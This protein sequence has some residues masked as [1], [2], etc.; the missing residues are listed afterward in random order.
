MTEQEMVLTSVLKCRRLDLYA[1][2]RVPSDAEL[3]QILRIRS[4]RKHHEPLQ[5]ILGTCEFFGLEFSV[6]RR[7]LVPRPETELLVEASAGLLGGPSRGALNVLDIGTGSGNIIISLAQQYP[8]HHFFAIDV[9]AEALEV[10]RK[11][12]LTHDVLPRIEFAQADILSSGDQPALKRTYDIIVANPPYIPQGSLASLPP[13]VRQEPRLALDGGVDGL[14]FYRAIA[15]LAANQLPARGHCC[16]EIG[17]GQRDEV[18]H[19]FLSTDCFEI[20]ECR[21]DH[22]G[23]ERALIIQRI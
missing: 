3:E 2:E 1:G 5:Y 18:E 4:R 15:R 22:S 23:I 13:E 10:A 11:N 21:K 20:V 8:Q 14:C 7:V 6:D 17:F 19:I 12:A 9:S 16:L